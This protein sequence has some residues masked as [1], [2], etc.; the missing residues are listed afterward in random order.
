MHRALTRGF[1]SGA[2]FDEL[3]EL[4]G[5]GRNHVRVNIARYVERIEFFNTVEN[6]SETEEQ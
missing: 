3:S 6:P 5:I 4:Y 1:A 2:T